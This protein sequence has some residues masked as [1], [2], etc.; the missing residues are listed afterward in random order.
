MYTPD[1]SIF[2]LF[3]SCTGAVHMYAVP[4]HV[5]S[6]ITSKTPLLSLLHAQSRRIIFFAIV[7]HVIE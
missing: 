7:W 1:F 2:N 6:F 4:E 3:F 5:Y